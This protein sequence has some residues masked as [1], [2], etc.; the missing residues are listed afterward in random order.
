MSTDETSGSES[1]PQKSGLGRAL[2][3]LAERM[4]QAPGQFEGTIVLRLEGD[5]GGIWSIH[6]T[7]EEARVVPGAS[8]GEY[9]A[10]VLG[11][12]TTIRE[13]LEGKTDGRQ[14]LLGGGIRVRGDIEF[15]ERLSAALG[16]HQ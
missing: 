5:E 11:D 9:R 4:A 2:E 15:L 10:E 14:A 7:S 16:T 8:S 1:A 3:S 6:S 12:A 13:V